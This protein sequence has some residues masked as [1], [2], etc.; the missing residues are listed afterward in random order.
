M[1]SA[2]SYR[3]VI[4]TNYESHSEVDDVTYR[5]VV[6]KISMVR[7]FEKTDESAN[8]RFYIGT[9]SKGIGIVYQW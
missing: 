5:L 8:V 1:K 2:E 3:K 4:Y 6:H 9:I 7:M